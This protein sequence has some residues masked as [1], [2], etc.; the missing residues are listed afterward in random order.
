MTRSMLVIASVVICWGLMGRATAGEVQFSSRPETP[1][2]AAQAGAKS[3][4][5]AKAYRLQYGDSTLLAK[6]LSALPLAD[7]RIVADQRT[8]SIIVLAPAETQRA[9]A[10]I[11]A[12]LDVPPA[13][14]SPSVAAP[15]AESRHEN[16]RAEAQ[17]TAPGTMNENRLAPPA[18]R[19]T[20]APTG[21]NVI[22]VPPGAQTAL[23]DILSQAAGSAPTG[24]QDTELRALRVRQIDPELLRKAM[25]EIL[26]PGSDRGNTSVRVM[27]VP[28]Q[29]QKAVEDLASRFGQAQNT[30]PPASDFNRRVTILQ[31]PA[32]QIGPLAKA[33]AELLPPEETQ[34]AT[35]P[36]SQPA[37]GE[38]RTAQRG[39]SNLEPTQR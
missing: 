35:A 27:K 28:P 37:V 13:G 9:I 10:P 15:P 34:L 4:R 32:G 26:P 11:I 30:P 19:G 33:L 24:G 7:T 16:Q 21:V 38:P 29:V 3:A 8:N 6:D 17:K 39:G 5:E 25:K 36:A 2:E 12:R 14:V 1:V 20:P 23:A 22:I 18:A 31:F